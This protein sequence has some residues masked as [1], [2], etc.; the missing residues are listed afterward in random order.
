[1][2]KLGILLLLNFYV[3]SGYSSIL[4]E[5]SYTIPITQK[6]EGLSEIQY[7]KVIDKV[8]NIYSPIVEELGMKLKIERLWNDPRVNAGT[9]KMGKEVIIRMYGGY[10]RHPSI[11]EDAFALV[12]CHELG[13]HLGGAPRKDLYGRGPEW[14]SVE[15]QA[16]YFATL[17]CL[18]KVF[19]KDQNSKIISNFEV[20][21]I[22][23][24]TCTNAFPTEWE[25]AIC[26]RTTLAGIAN[27]HISS[28][29]RG[30]QPPTVDT[31][32]P[33]IVSETFEAHPIPQC[34][35]DT[36][37]Q[38]SI[39]K[40]SSDVFV[41]SENEATGTCHQLNN[42]ATGMRPLCWFSPK[43][44]QIIP[45]RRYELQEYRTLKN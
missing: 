21:E 1:M 45:C 14:P 11:T 16:D 13:H 43:S 38:G 39:C 42:H 20:P 22:I 30:H 24:K 18:R 12:I 28:L 31:P 37:F 3:F 8:E 9:I 27:S 17:K 25:A 26:I 40:V 6:N 10:A 36:Y 5:N 23:Q 34:R 7:H 2:R 19:R 35:L 41:S 44:F 29:I 4:P 15:G 32:D 33:N